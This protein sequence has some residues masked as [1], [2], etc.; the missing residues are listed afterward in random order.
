MLTL[1]HAS[2]LHF[3]AEDTAA[4]AW[5]ADRVAA[6]KPDA[7]LCTGDL[8]MRGTT[9]EFDRAAHWLAQFDTPWWIEPGNHDV[10]YYWELPRRLSRPFA[11]FEAMRART[12]QHHGL[13]SLTVVSLPTVVAAQWRLN[14]SKGCV[15]PSALA[16]AV[17]DLHHAKGRGL[18]LV[19]GHHPLIDGKTHGTGSTRHGHAALA[20]LAQAGADAVLSGHV[21]DPFDRTEP[22]GGKEIR[23]I[24]A[25]TLSERL[26]K[27]PPGFNVLRWS[28]EQ[29][30][31]VQIVQMG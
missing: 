24:G 28:P 19:L 1:F 21:H 14:W 4:L 16:Q 17:A 3:G 25:G 22:A 30:L 10:P 12:H 13:E 26:R 8:T 11:R 18:K 7:I 2:D 29:G 9:R 27:T 23:L 6:E 20:A 5:F 31:Q 15:R